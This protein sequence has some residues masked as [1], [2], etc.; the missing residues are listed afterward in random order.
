MFGRGRTFDRI[1]LAIAPG[2]TIAGAERELRDL[3]GPGFQ[4]DPPSARGQQFEAMA[5][6][7]SIMVNI[8]SLLALFIG[9]FIIYNSFAIAVTQRRAEIGILRALGATR[10]QIRRLFLAESAVTG[11]AGSLGGVL[12]GLLIARGIAAWIGT[13]L[14]DVY[15][16]AQRAD[17]IATS[18]ALL[19][20]ALAVGVA[21]SIIA[22]LIPAQQA[23]RVDPVLA[24]QKGRYQVLSAGESR[25]RAALAAT[26]GATSIAC[27]WAGD[28]R[29]AFYAGFALAILVALLLGPLLAL[30]LSKAVRPVLKWLRPVEGA[31]A[32]DSLIQAPRRT[33]ASVAALMLS[34][35]VVVSFAGM[36][37]GSY[38][39]IIGWMDR[40]LNPDLFV[41]PSQDIVDPDAALPGRDG[42]GAPGRSRH[43]AHPAGAQRA[44]R[45]PA[46]PGDDRGHR[47][48]EPVG[49]TRDRPGGRRSGHDVP[50][51][52]RR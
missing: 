30:A 20:L 29:A 18:P 40:A 24:L 7:Y 49:D 12:F 5:A 22:A 16:V 35:A 26:L 52:S 36:A 51:D 32:A 39:S 38:T 27:L 43:R 33:S 44:D 42:G 34:L 45:L 48:R 17:E 10:R 2:R 23:A 37:R 25:A 9:M 41:I 4:V 50:D 3:L 21:T 46:D 47:R 28:S 14:S 13:L 11:L 8:S 6:A 31:L 15:G 19:L 1:D